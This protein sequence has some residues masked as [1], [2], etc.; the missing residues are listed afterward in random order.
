MLDPGN[1]KIGKI[2]G[3]FLSLIRLKPNNCLLSGKKHEQENAFLHINKSETV[4]NVNFGC[5]RFCYKWK[6]TRIGSIDME[7][8]KI[9][10]AH[11]F[12]KRKKNSKKKQSVE[13][14]YI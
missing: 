7:N 6:T 12:E 10:I 4:Y 8:Y 1:F 13:F 9:F 11:F 14:S 5:Y 2:N 3:N